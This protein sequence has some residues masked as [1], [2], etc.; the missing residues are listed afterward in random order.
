M[1][2]KG[3]IRV[4]YRVIVCGSRDFTDKETCFGVLDAFLADK[5]DAEIVSGHARGA[6]AFGEEYAR[7]RGLALT[8]FAAEW[9]RYGRAA[10]PLRNAQM[11]AYAMEETP[12]VVAFWDGKSAGTAHMARLAEEKGA[13]VQIVRFSAEETETKKEETE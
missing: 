3:G 12:C 13:E 6:D 4:K 7:A 2:A 1:E 5:P 8:V 11:L 10:G 9:G